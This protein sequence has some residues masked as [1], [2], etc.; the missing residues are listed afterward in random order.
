M[1]PNRM[2]IN[3]SKL[4]YASNFH[5]TCQH[6]QDIGGGL[7]TT[8]PAFRDWKNPALQPYIQKYLASKD[9]VSR[10]TVSAYYDS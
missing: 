6:L 1:M 10:R 3:A 4:T 8:V 9:G 5:Q 7:T 2:A